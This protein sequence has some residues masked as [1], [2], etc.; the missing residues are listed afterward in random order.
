MTTNNNTINERNPK[1][2]KCDMLKCKGFCCYDGVYISAEE[3]KRLREII[4][5]HKDYFNLSAD[6][7]FEDGNWHN[8][9]K[10]RK[11]ATREFIYPDN[12]P[13]HFNQTKCIF[14]DDEGLCA[15][16]KLAI[17]EGK[18]PWIYKPLACCLFPLVEK[19]GQAV[20]PP[21]KNQPDDY[22]VDENYKGFIN[23]LYCGQ[24]CD[25]GQNWQDVLKDELN[26]FEKHHLTN[27][28]DE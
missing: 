11:T 25:D 4:N 3:E 21:N 6:S 14:S 15:F 28:I 13:K 23:C 10:G 18:H 27:K 8:K 2:K 12:F 24:D 7:Y 20:P 1:L 22:Y 17:K 9:V 19:N 5:N 26:W 16:Q